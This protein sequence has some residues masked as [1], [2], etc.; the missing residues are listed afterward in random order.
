MKLQAR[1]A[2]PH[3]NQSLKFVEMFGTL[4]TGQAV[5]GGSFGL[6]ADQLQ[7]RTWMERCR[8]LDCVKDCLAHLSYYLPLQ[9]D[10]AST[11]KRRRLLLWRPFNKKVHAALGS[12]S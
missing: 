6:D 1:Q 7:S 4:G 2:V 11:C 10:L 5:D 3:V 9:W 12:R 8:F